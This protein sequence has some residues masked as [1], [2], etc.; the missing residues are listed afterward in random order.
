MYVKDFVDDDGRTRE[1]RGLNITFLEKL[2]FTHIC[3]VL[4]NKYPPVTLSLPPQYV[5]PLPAENPTAFGW[6]IKGQK[7][8]KN[9]MTVK[10]STN[11]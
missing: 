4:R 5:P 2:E 3:T 10:K 8:E 11:Y 7:V 1:A 9:E 6:E